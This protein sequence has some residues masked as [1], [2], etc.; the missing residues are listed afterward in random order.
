MVTGAIAGIL[1]GLLGVG[2]GIVI[3]PVL[4]LLADFLGFPSELAMPMAV[5]TSLA[6]IIPTSMSSARSHHKRGSMDIDLLKVWAPFV[7]AGAA[8][9]GVLASFVSGTFLTLL[10]GVIA[11]IVAVNLALPKAIVVAQALPNGVLARTTV[12]TGVGVFS[13][14]MGIGGGTL[15]V[16][17]LTAFSYPVHRAIGTAAA[18]GLVIAVPAV[19]GFIWAVWAVVGRPPL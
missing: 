11:L 13:A 7:F 15:S 10:F 16:P 6:T 5:G 8:L 12:P 9:G 17:I 14:L 1:A 3:V 2:G 4:F 19:C 18:L